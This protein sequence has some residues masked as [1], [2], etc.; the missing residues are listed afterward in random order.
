MST[1]ERSTGRVFLTVLLVTATLLVAINYLVGTADDSLALLLVLVLLTLVSAVWTYAGQEAPAGATAIQAATK[2]EM[3][4]RAAEQAAED[5]RARAEQTEPEA[6]PVEA[7]EP[8]ASPA[9]PDDL[10]R[11]EGV[12]KKYAD[13]LAA[14]GI[15]TYAKLSQASLDELQAAADAAGLTNRASMET[16]AEQAVYA[17]RG[18]WDGLQKFQDTLDGGRRK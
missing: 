4:A 3:A 12:G 15:N 5:T 9:E 1:E 14:A 13:A 11:I 7:A 18:D 10:T 17:A 8:E 6:P 16:W 2:A